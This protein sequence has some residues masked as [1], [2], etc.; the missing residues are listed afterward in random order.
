MIHSAPAMLKV[1]RMHF[2]LFDLSVSLPKHRVHL[3][4]SIMLSACLLPFASY[5]TGMA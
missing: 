3:V 4:E 5:C 2:D 1:E